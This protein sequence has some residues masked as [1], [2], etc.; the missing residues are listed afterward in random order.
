MA[1]TDVEIDEGDFPVIGAAFEATG[2]TRRRRVGHATGALMAQRPLVD[3]ATGWM[4]ER[5]A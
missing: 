1:F 3:F 2:S 4:N 5:R